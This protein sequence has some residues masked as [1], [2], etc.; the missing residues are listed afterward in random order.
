MI[1]IDKFDKELYD[2]I[3]G[4]PKEH[5][6]FKIWN[7]I[8]NNTKI[9]KE[10]IKVIK[11]QFNEYDTL[12]ATTIAEQILLFHDKVD[13]NIYN[14]LIKIVFSNID[15]ARTVVNGSYN[16]GYSFLLISLCNPSLKLTKNQKIFAI[17]EAMN[18]IGTSRY[19][20]YKNRLS[21]KL[22]SMNINDT[23]TITTNFGNEKNSIGFK[24][25]FMYINDLIS[26]LSK[27][28][29]HGCGCYDIRY[30]ILKNHNWTIMEKK[31]LIMNFWYDDDDYN[32]TFKQWENNIINKLIKYNLRGN[33]YEYDYTTLLIILNNKEET[34]EIYSEIVF[35]KLMKELRPLKLE[36]KNS[37][38]KILK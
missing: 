35:C 10:S 33:I 32:N 12:K 26:S 21:K 17:N 6:F 34:N 18:K 23:N 5:D 9:L 25:Y 24:S 2:S 3:Y 15:I 11:D 38:E 29:A 20:Q 4:N 19:V 8:I 28:Q 22:E 16:G 13:S 31:K 37:K 36:L 30:Y 27:T 7:K 14:K 1:N